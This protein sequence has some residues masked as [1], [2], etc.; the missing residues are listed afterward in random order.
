VETYYK[1]NQERYAEKDEKGNVK[2]QKPF[3]EVAQQVARD[4]IMEKKQQAYQRFIERLM[5][6]EKVVVYEDKIK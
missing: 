3:S 5:K 4:F 2:R 6:A 1:A